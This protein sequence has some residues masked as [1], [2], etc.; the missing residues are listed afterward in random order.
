MGL[1]GTAFTF[2]VTVVAVVLPC[3]ETQLLPMGTWAG[4]I[5]VGGSA[6]GPTGAS[7]AFLACRYNVYGSVT[8]LVSRPALPCIRAKRG[9]LPPCV[10]AT[11]WFRSLYTYVVTSFGLVPAAESW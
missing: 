4:W 2:T 3:V 9:F 1:L 10:V 6:E 5:C 11:S 8:S 7:R